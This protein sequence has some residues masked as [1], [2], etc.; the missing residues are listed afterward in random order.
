M[1][2]MEARRN[3]KLG[4]IRDFTQSIA[5]AGSDLRDLEPLIM[6]YSLYLRQT[7]QGTRPDFI[8]QRDI[9]DPSNLASG[10]ALSPWHAAA[11]LEDRTRTAAFIRGS[12]R[13]VEAMLE[14]REHRPLHLLEAGCGP[15]ATLIAPLLSWFGPEELVVSLIDIHQ[16]SIDNCLSLL[17]TLGVRNRV[18]HAVC[19]D[20]TTVSVDSPVDICLSETMN[21]ALA[22]EPQV[23]ITRALVRRYPNALLLPQSIRVNL[24]FIDWAAESSAFPMRG[25]RSLGRGTGVRVE[26]AHCGNTGGSRRRITRR[27]PA[28][29]G[30]RAASACILYNAGRGVPG[31]KL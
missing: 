30:L 3:S 18:R 21:A 5:D 20:I 2:E 19:G 12:I 6:Q 31:H 16:D 11:C 29:T 13:A 15:V 22:S 26:R 24:E 7:L 4:K 28:G 17:D 14:A 8:Q 1:T 25:G 23:A 27:Q 10:D 9:H